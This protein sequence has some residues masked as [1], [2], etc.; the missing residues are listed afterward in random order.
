MNTLSQ[1]KLQAARSVSE[2]DAPSIDLN[3]PWRVIKCH[4][5]IQWIPRIRNRAETVARGVWRRRSYCRTRE[6]L[7]R[8]R[9][10]YADFL[11]AASVTVLTARP[12]LLCAHLWAASDT[13]GSTES[14]HAY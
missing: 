6:A 10:R 12:E 1:L 7:I 9:D 3:A 4:Y 14:R 8:C 5:G 2:S 11:D 13:A